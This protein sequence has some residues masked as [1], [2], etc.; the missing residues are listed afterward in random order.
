M[1]V[2]YSVRSDV[3]VKAQF[4]KI[5]TKPQVWH[6]KSTSIVKLANEITNMVNS[7]TQL[8][9]TSDL[10]AVAGLSSATYK[11]IK[12]FSTTE[13]R[14]ITVYENSWTTERKPDCFWSVVCI[15]SGFL[16]EFVCT[17]KLSFDR[18]KFQSPDKPKMSIFASNADASSK[19]Q[20][21][22]SPVKDGQYSI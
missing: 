2:I 13:R 20:N 21:Q 6:H 4:K 1:L 17:D 15:Q 3:I 19:P 8:G 16:W 5:Q 14:T 9:Y 18:D 11:R 22:E 12:I 7:L 10:V